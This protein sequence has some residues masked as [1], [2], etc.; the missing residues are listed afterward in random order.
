MT[1]SNPEVTEQAEVQPPVKPQLSAKDR[2]IEI[3]HEELNLTKDHA[4]KILQQLERRGV[5]VHHD[6][7]KSGIG[8]M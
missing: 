3:L 2:A 1:E 8:G 6:T 4:E 7:A 5:L